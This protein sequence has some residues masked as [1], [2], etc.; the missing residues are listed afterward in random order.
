MR[1][2]VVLTYI[3]VCAYMCEKQTHQ[4]SHFLPKEFITIYDF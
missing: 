2:T 4:P 3:L 1:E